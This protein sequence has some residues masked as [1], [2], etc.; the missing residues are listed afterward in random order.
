MISIRKNVFETNSSSCHSI[1]VC[2]SDLRKRIEQYECIYVGEF[3]YHDDY[4]LYT[5][6]LNENS[7]LSREAV[8]NIL[9]KFVNDSNINENYLKDYQI[10][11]KKHDYENMSLFELD[12]CNDFDLWDI[13][14][15]YNIN[16]T[17]T[18]VI[19]GGKDS[20]TS[21]YSDNEFLDKVTKEPVSVLVAQISC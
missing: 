13:L 11:L 6:I 17:R 12:H 9:K 5:N 19:F 15:L 8:I 10:Q 21:I 20:D 1:V 2:K 18:E 3:D 14:Q 4:E 7:I 16:Y